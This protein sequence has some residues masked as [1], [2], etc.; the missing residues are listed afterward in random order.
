MK[1]LG[2]LVF[3][4]SLLVVALGATGCT[5][6]AVDAEDIPSEDIEP[7]ESSEALTA[8]CKGTGAKSGEA[9]RAAVF[10]T[11]SAVGAC[12]TPLKFAT[13]VGCFGAGALAA[14]SIA[15]AQAAKQTAIKCGGDEYIIAALTCSPARYRELLGRMQKACKPFGSSVPACVSTQAM[16]TASVDCAKAESAFLNGCNLTDRGY[17]DAYG[18]M[19]N[20]SYCR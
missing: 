1:N 5:A 15:D 6:E 12:V 10:N 11:L 14:S 19:N 17:W 8:S 9:A 4:S 3:V 16:F 7:G 2:T 20:M 18:K 13:K